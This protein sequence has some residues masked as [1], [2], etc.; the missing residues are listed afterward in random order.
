[1]NV[2]SVIYN[3]QYYTSIDLRYIPA[4]RH[5]IGVLLSAALIA[6]TQ[7]TATTLKH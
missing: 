6:N 7:N 2:D 4:S 1:M 3:L 5:V